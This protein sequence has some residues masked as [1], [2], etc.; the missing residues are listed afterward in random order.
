M[1]VIQYIRKLKKVYKHGQILRVVQKQYASK[2]YLNCISNCHLMI[3][4]I[5]NDFFGYYYR[6]LCY[7][8]L[9]FFQEALSDMETAYCNQ[10]KN[11]FPKLMEEYS[12]DVELRIAN[13]FRLQ[14]K[15]GLAIEKLNDL[16]SRNPDFVNGYIEMVGV[17][18]DI[19]DPKSALQVVN[20]GLLQYPN[21]QDLKDAQS[22]L[23]YYSTSKRPAH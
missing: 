6:G 17:Y 1:R 16:L 9:K 4:L 20:Q 13:I 14:R 7:L 18:M 22:N 11:R 8:K 19:E 10:K 23:I 15:Y 5:E 3:E 21:N 12:R 2:A